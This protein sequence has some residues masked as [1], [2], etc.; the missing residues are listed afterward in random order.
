MGCIQSTS[1]R[2]R[3][4]IPRQQE[5]EVEI[6][7][8][9]QQPSDEDDSGIQLVSRSLRKVLRETCD[10]GIQIRADREKFG[11]SL[12]GV[13]KSI[14]ALRK[15]IRAKLNGN[16]MEGS[17]ADDYRVLLNAISQEYVALIAAEIAARE[18]DHPSASGSVFEFG[19]TSGTL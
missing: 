17:G 10:L 16:V 2:P 11:E 4:P 14:I 7:R 8:T 15:R 9:P 19:S 6:I 18:S 3:S 1:S 12:A 5:A 13:E